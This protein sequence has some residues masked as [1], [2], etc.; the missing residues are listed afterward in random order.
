MKQF[1]VTIGALLWYISIWFSRNSDCF[2]YSNAI[3]DEQCSEYLRAINWVWARYEIIDDQLHYS[4]WHD[5]GLKTNIHKSV[6]VHLDTFEITFID[7]FTHIRWWNVY[8][9]DRH[10]LYHN[11]EAV[12]TLEDESWAIEFLCSWYTKRGWYIH[13]PWY[14]KI[15]INWSPVLEQGFECINSFLFKYNG[16]IYFD[17]ERWVQHRINS[18]GQSSK[19]S[20]EFLQEFILL[21]WIDSDSFAYL[22]HWFFEDKNW[23]Y[24]LSINNYEGAYTKIDRADPQTFQIHVRWW[25]RISHLTDH[26]DVYFKI[27]NS[28][29]NW[30]GYI[31]SL[32]K[33]DWADPNSVSIDEY[34]VDFF[35]DKNRVYKYNQGERTLSVLEW[36]DWSTWKKVVWWEVETYGYYQDKNHVYRRDA[37]LPWIDW[38][39]R[40]PINWSS[41]RWTRIIHSKDKNNVYYHADHGNLIPLE[42]AYPTQTEATWR[43][44]LSSWSLFFKWTDVW[45]YDVEEFELLWNWYMSVNGLIYYDWKNL[46]KQDWFREI[47][48]RAIRSEK[49]QKYQ[50]KLNAEKNDWVPMF[51]LPECL[52]ATSWW[53]ENNSKY[54]AFYTNDAWDIILRW[55]IIPMFADE[56]DFMN[57][58]EHDSIWNDILYIN[59]SWCNTD[60]NYHLQ[61][62][63]ANKIDMLIVEK[64]VPNIERENLEKTLELQIIKTSNY[65]WWTLEE[66]IEWAFYRHI[67]R[68]LPDYYL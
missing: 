56:D 38:D 60:P 25:D 50:E 13:A 52:P 3:N 36:A 32:I 8:A 44:L 4:P 30:E 41:W 15:E 2:V 16:N 7:E 20:Y 61:A 53:S 37:K 29:L 24:I 64:I 35:H 59:L 19:P 5:N 12:T 42:G 49:K 67:L 68:E 54:N 58:I 48:I 34:Y 1:I 17:T 45:V 11:G 47:D 65:Y 28:T 63:R 55:H 33:I 62:K 31:R 18:W 39:S 10:Y 46:W 9:K 57:S 27:R 23:V 22:S 21:E 66:A 26:D 40:E 43:Y 14:N 51:T 6:D